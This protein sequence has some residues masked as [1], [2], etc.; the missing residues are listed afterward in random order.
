M[1]SKKLE[2]QM[3]NKKTE[4][5][6]RKVINMVDN[7][8]GKER[9]DYMQ[10]IFTKAMVG[11]MIIKAYK[12]KNVNNLKPEYRVDAMGMSALAGAETYF[13]IIDKELDKLL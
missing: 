3:Q 10:L 2:Q 13:A 1:S 8:E 4:E 6:V 12:D 9:D 11:D 7:L 5:M